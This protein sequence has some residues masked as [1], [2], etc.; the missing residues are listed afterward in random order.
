MDPK[1]R[2]ELEASGAA[3]VAES[4]HKIWLKWQ[5][6]RPGRV[7]PKIVQE[8]VAQLVAACKADAS[9]YSAMYITADGVTK[10]IAV[11]QVGE[12]MCTAQVEVHLLG[13]P[14]P[15]ARVLFEL[16]R[17]LEQEVAKV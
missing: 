16:K 11:R 5:R 14:M 13:S 2:Q 3:P 15:A 6:L 12:R 9:W 17:G 10:L 4:S 8:G 1:L 7:V